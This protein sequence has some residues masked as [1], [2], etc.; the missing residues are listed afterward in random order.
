MPAHY[1]DPAYSYTDYWQT[2]DYEHQSEIL[3]LQKLLSHHKFKTIADIGGG[4]GRLVP[5]L[6]SYGTKIILIEPSN[7]LRAIA[8]KYLFLKKLSILPGTAQHTRL[9]NSSVDLVTIIRVAHHIPDLTSTLTELYRILKPRGQVILEFANSNNF[10]ARLSSVITG[11]PIL[12][13]PIEKR[14]PINIKRQTIP[15]V[16]HHPQTILK[17]LSQTGFRVRTQLSVSNFRSSFLKKIIP[18]SIL[19]TLEKYL[20]PLLGNLY[21]GPSI[22]LLLDKQTDP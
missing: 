16:N 1:D 11:R 6:S 20:Q 12:P 13:I 4:F 19:L 7:K 10:K 21:F 5:T 2:R 14:S 17:L 22:F 18:A 8:K 9:P 15:F 3:A